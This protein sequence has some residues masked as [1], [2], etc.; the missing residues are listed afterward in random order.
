MTREQAEKHTILRCVVGSTVHGL[1]V[2]DGVEDRDE[3]GVVVE[4][5]EDAI[6]LHAEFEQFIYR[7]AAEREGK[8]DARS[9]AGDLDLTL[10]SMRKWLRLALKGN[11]T[12]ITPL[13]VTRESGHL[14]VCDALGSKL[15]ELSPA[16]IS[17]K[18]GGAFLG[19]LTAQKQRMMGERGQLKV[20]RPEL[21]ARDGYDSKYAMHMLR[22]GYQGT[23]LMQT[24]RITLPIP[25]PERAWLRA[26]RLGEVPLQEVLTRAGE[27]ERVLK[28]SWT[29]SPLREQPDED[30]VEAFLRE[31]Y[32][33]MWKARKFTAVL[34]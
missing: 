15:R 6:G 32:W 9:F 20:H 24:G 34:V 13:F 28:D 7:T 14:L 31:T 29:D 19:Y 23:E 2:S 16:L 5:F 26:V 22:L 33:E 21:V 18:A 10:Y 27:Y 11:P 17:R 30:A 8:H 1:H 12:V 25:E 3:M 4:D